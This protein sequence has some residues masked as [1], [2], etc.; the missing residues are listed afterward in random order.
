MNYERI[1]ALLILVVVVAAFVMLVI[2]SVIVAGPEISADHCTSY[3]TQSG[4]CRYSFTEYGLCWRVVQWDETN[5]RGSGK[6]CNTRE[7][8]NWQTSR[9]DGFYS[10]DLSGHSLLLRSS[11]Y[12]TTATVPYTACFRYDDQ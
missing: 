11:I 1:E 12:S 8:S 10:P 6:L 4:I 2:S 7:N 3:D 9:R 5:H